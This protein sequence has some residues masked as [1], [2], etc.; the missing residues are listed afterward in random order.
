[1]ADRV[2]RDHSEKCVHGYEWSHPVPKGEGRAL[3]NAFG[4]DDCSGGRE[5]TETE[6]VRLA[7]EAQ[8]TDPTLAA[9]WA[10]VFEQGV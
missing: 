5:V 4:Y 3:G 10:D 2:L 1:M 7:A 9:V 6:L 8:R